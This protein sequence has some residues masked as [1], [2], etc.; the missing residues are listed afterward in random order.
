[1]PPCRSPTALAYTASTTSWST[2]GWGYG[3]RYPSPHAGWPS[4]H[5]TQSGITKPRSTDGGVGASG[6]ERE[7]ALTYWK[8]LTSLG[9]NSR[10]HEGHLVDAT[11]P[12][13]PDRK[14]TR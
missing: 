9:S 11:L 5:G 7:N 4:A 12:H 6:S 8:N 2:T 13:A 1:M 14:S 10:H 3:R